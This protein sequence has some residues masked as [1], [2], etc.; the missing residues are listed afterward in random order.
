LDSRQE[1]IFAYQLYYIF[2]VKDYRENK[3]DFSGVAIRAVDDTT[4]EFRMNSP[5]SYFLE[6]LS[7]PI[8]TLRKVDNNLK[9]W[10]YNYEHISYS[11]PFTVDHI[12][13]SGE[14]SLLKNEFYYNKDEVKSDRIYL[15]SVLE[16]E[17]AMAGFVNKKINMFINP[18]LSESQ[19]LILEGNAEVTPVDSGASINFNLKKS[20]IVANSSFRK[21]LNLAINRESLVQEDLNYLA[22]SASAYVPYDEGNIA[23]KNLLEENENIGLANKMLEESGYKKK[24]K[25]KLIYLANNENR[26]LCEDLVK[27]IKD[28]LDIN[29]EYKGCNEVEF[30]ETLKSGDYDMLIMNYASL[31]D[32]PLSLLESFEGTSELNL[33]GYKNAEFDTTVNKAKLEKD[34]KKRLELLRKGEEILINDMPVIPI[35]FHNIL[36]CKDPNIKDVYITK[37]G[38]VRLDKAYID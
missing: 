7:Q 26:R 10:I 23:L 38:N 31:Y 1:N 4:L 16:S 18:P 33:F 22:R 6:I 20:G 24:E 30:K 12:S 8:F 9:A 5:V 36:L 29:L 11:G 14:V 28:D 17:K 3:K 13:E 27:D 35:Y 21:A 2:G 37:E 32:D 19:N 15:T 25:V 34:N